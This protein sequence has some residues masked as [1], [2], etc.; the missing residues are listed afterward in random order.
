MSTLRKVMMLPITPQLCAKV[1]IEYRKVISESVKG[2]FFDHLGKVFSAMIN[3]GLLPADA[4]ISFL[5]WDDRF[6]AW[7]VLI[8]SEMYHELPHDKQAP[9]LD[10]E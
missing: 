3:E 10:L 1:C 6:D 4:K 8:E 7:V 2:V 5:Y 9:L